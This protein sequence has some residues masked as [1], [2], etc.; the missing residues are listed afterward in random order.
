MVVKVA[1][2]DVPHRSDFGAVVLGVASEADLRAAVERIERNV[3]SHMPAAV[4]DGFELQEELVDCVEAMVG[5]KATPPYGALIVVGTGGVLVELEADKA[6]SLCPVTAI[7]ARTMIAGTRLGRAL[8]GYRGLIPQTDIMPLARLVTSLSELATAC[9]GAIEE[10]DLN[11]VMIRKGS[12]EV[13]IV[14][15]LLVVE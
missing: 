6:T 12:G 7:E 13:R 3:R 14:D 5:F 10:C 1:S 11:P 2:R 15:A 9:C 8:A 4:I